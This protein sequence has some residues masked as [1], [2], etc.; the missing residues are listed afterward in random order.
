MTHRLG[1]LA[2]V[3]IVPLL[4]AGPAVAADLLSYDNGY[5]PEQYGDNGYPPEQYGTGV[6]SAAAP[7]YGANG[8]YG[9]QTY[10]DPN[11]PYASRGP[12]APLQPYPVARAPNEPDDRYGDRGPYDGV[13]RE[14]AIVPNSR[15]GD[16]PDQYGH[17]PVP[18][19]QALPRY[20][21]SP[22]ES[23][24]RGGP[25]P[26]V[27]AYTDPRGYG[28]EQRAQP[29]H[30]PAE[31]YDR[32]MQPSDHAGPPRPAVGLGANAGPNGYAPDRTARYGGYPAQNGYAP[33]PVPQ[34]EYSSRRD[35]QEG[36]PPE[37]EPGNPYDGYSY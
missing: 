31:S 7:V 36:P 19:P 20:G 13:P 16:Y 2:L 18:G 1:K 6:P 4:I 5:P 12:C 8:G 3:L 26:P 27:G 21:H 34:S 29:P 35:Y 30:Y 32:S 23:G 11:D 22:A 14:A 15:Y 33:T 9:A 37:G 28:A 24:Y 25:N 17:R 10:C